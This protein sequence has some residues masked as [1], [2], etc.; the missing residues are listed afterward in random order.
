MARIE[1]CNLVKSFGAVQA[2]KDLSF[3]IEDGEFVS[4]GTPDIRYNDLCIRNL[5]SQFPIGTRVVPG[6]WRELKPTP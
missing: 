1:L 2:V 4:G 5:D 6:Y 3:T